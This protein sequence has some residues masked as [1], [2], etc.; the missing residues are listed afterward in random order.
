MS[1]TTD[2]ISVMTE[3]SQSGST[4]V[5]VS[6]TDT[7]SDTPVSFQKPS[8]SAVWKHFRRHHQSAQC[9][10]CKKV[11]SYHGGTTSN[12]IRHL[13]KKHQ[14]EVEVQ[15]VETTE[16]TT[17]SSYQLRSLGSYTRASRLAS[18]VRWKQKKK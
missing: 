15:K 14:S 17:Q 3:E 6:S 2:T 10:L 1:D 8:R 9:L 12:L 13:N 11:L 18:L 16:D 5:T 4:T 7:S